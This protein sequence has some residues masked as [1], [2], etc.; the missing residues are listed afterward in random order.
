MPKYQVTATM[1]VGYKAI[2]EAPTEAE[3]WHKAK[4]D[5]TVSWQQTDDGHDW[6]MEDIWIMDARV[7]Y[8]IGEIK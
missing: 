6:T 7:P 5:S 4:H 2:V 3:A 1:D 8:Q